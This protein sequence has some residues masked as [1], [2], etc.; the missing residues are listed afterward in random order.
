M[1]WLLH[2]PE[3]DSEVLFVH[4]YMCKKKPQLQENVNVFMFEFFC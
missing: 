4:P 3:A 1:F 2:K